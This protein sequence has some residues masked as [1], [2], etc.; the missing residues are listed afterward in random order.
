MTT[1]RFAAK[2]GSVLAGDPPTEQGIAAVLDRLGLPHGGLRVALQGGTATLAGEVPDPEMQEQLLLAVGNL[3]G[4][5]AVW[6][7]TTVT[8][9]SGLLDTVGAFAH[10]PTGSA[11]TDA[12]EEEVHRAAPVPDAMFGPAGS[13]LHRVRPGETLASIAARHYGSEAEAPRFLHAN[14]AMVAEAV[15]IEPGIVLRLP[16]R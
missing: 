16:L 5:G 14:A 13:L 2:V 7:D 3:R 9:R 8:R 11:A 1:Y 6:D 12:A 15:P 10:L 4:I